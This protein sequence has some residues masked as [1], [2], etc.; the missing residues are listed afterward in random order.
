MS[1]EKP[2]ISSNQP[3][4]FNTRQVTNTDKI[5]I[6]FCKRFSSINHGAIF[7][8]EKVVQAIKQSSNSIAA[9]PDRLKMPHLKHL[10]PRG[11]AFLTHH[12]KFSL[13]SADIPSI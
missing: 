12:F 4:A 6:F 3:I 2:R 9:G 10:G 13:Q 7:T 1:G 11:H 5:A 8:T